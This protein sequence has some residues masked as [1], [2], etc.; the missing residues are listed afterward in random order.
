VLA[1]GSIREDDSHESYRYTVSGSFR[2][3]PRRQGLRRPLWL[4]LAP[5][6]AIG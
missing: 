1:A 5:L 4:L 3:V 2:Q 6:A